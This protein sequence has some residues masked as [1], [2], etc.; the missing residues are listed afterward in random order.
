MFID[1][2]AP[3]S[4]ALGLIRTETG[5]GLFGLTLKY[6]QTQLTAQKRGAQL[7]ITGPRAQVAHD[8]AVRFLAHHQRDSQLEI[9]IEWAVANGMGFGS[10][11]MLALSTAQALAWL[12]DLPIDDVSALARAIGLGSE[13]ALAVAGFQ[14]GGALLVGLDDGTVMRRAVIEHDDDNVWALVLHFPHP[15]DDAPLTL[16]ADALAALRR[17]APHLSA[18]TGRV[19][20]EQLWPAIEQNDLAAFAHAV[21]AIDELNHDALAEAGTPSTL[22]PEAQDVLDAMRDNGALACSQ[23]LLGLGLWALVKGT[24]A[25]QKLRHQLR[26]HVGYFAGTQLAGI[27]DNVGARYTLKDGSL[28]VLGDTPIRPI[29]GAPQP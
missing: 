13:H 10:E 11:P 2:T 12:N 22:A 17:A 6:P 25:S 27:V 23:S 21:M 14:Q 8:Y 20:A 1:L 26:A 29:R 15:P 24:G 28:D 5:T 7:T 18:E 4:L 9:A 19:F 16:E 3:S